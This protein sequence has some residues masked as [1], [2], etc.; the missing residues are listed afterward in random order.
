ML[1]LLIQS[2][3]GYLRDYYVLDDPTSPVRLYVRAWRASIG[4]HCLQQE[5]LRPPNLSRPATFI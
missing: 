1:L 3:H 5:K 4:S 2:D